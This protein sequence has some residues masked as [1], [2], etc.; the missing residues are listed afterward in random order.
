MVQQ[1]ALSH[2]LARVRKR[3]PRVIIG[4]VV[5]I[6]LAL[7]VVALILTT[8]K[9]VKAPDDGDELLRRKQCSKIAN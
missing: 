7:A 9:E 1:V 3:V 6:V 8:P 4:G 5:A 2:L